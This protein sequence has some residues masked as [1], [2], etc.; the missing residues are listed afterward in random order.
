MRAIKQ[1]NAKS[2]IPKELQ[3][4]ADSYKLKQGAGTV[5][6]KSSGFGG[7]GFKFDES[8]AVHAAE[9]KVRRPI[10][11]GRRAYH[12]FGRIGTAL[13]KRFAFSSQAL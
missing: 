11:P 9:G 7:S 3:A 4:L 8:E 10:F 1:A 12:A 5:A 6:R 2:Q 13:S